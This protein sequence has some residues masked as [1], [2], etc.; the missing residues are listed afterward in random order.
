[1]PDNNEFLLSLVEADSEIN[2]DPDAENFG[3]ADYHISG[4]VLTVLFED[5]DDSE[6]TEGSWKLVSLD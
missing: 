5:A 4:D 3:W 2:D 6:V 1:M